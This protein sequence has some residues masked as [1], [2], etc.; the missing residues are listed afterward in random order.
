M[1]MPVR[2]SIYARDEQAG[3]TAARA[4]FDRISALDRMMSDYRTDNE[5]RRLEGQPGAWV[6]VSEELF[7]VLVR[8]IEIAGATDGAFDPSVGPLVTLWRESRRSR[9]LPDRMTLD[10]ARALVGWQRIGLDA[11][12]RAVRLGVPG[13]RLDLGGIAK[14]YILQ[15]ALRTLRAQGVTRALLEAGGDLVVG[16]A[17][18]NRSGWR[19]EVPGATAPLAARAA[20]LTN[21]ALATSGATV[22]FVEIDGVRYSH[23]IN[24]RTGLGVTNHILAHVIAPDGATADALATAFTVIGPEREGEILAR[25]PGVIAHIGVGTNFSFCHPGGQAAKRLY[26]AAVC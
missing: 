3:R 15:E 13:M 5:L 1:G 16:D 6:A 11:G 22:Q 26:V 2:V 12:R 21:S 9:R 25:F 10:A 20:S 8:A 14:G 19:I 18:P 7:I 17:P 23:V 24:P 4:A